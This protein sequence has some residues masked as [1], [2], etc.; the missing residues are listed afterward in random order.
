M[1]YLA[2]NLRRLRKAADLT[3][4][5]VAEALSVSPQTV[6]KWERQ[7]TMPDIAMLPALSNLFHVSTDLLLGMDRINAADTIAGI[8]RAG[9][10][11][12]KGGDRKAAAAVYEQALTLYPGDP[13]ILCDLGMVLALE[14][15]GA[16][17]NRAEALCRKVLEKDT[18]KVSY[19][20]RA[21]L[22]YILEKMGKKDEA[23][24]AARFLPH[25]R[26]SREVITADLQAGLSADE[27]N[28]HIRYICLGE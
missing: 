10:A 11:L 24:A 12:L 23:L 5:E 3:Q 27:L 9:H 26:E 18:G 6:S 13:A 15:D 20:A 17:L 4:E 7:E 28:G 16:S 19:T 25:Q 2:E 22:C 21:A 1:I 14:E 8:F